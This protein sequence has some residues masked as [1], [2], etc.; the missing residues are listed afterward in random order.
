MFERVI[1]PVTP[2]P[3]LDVYDKQ[4][5]I[6]NENWLKS[7]YFIYKCPIPI[8]TW[9]IL[10]NTNYYFAGILILYENMLI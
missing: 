9:K 3:P 2:P 7:P 8:E 5:Y 4:D 1:Q 10:L 6:K